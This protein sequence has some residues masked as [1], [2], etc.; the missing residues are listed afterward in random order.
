MAKKEINKL[1]VVC[2]CERCGYEWEPR[3]ENRLPVKCPRCQSS[4][5]NKKRIREIKNEQ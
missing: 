1:V 5:W 3:L 2:I 4:Y